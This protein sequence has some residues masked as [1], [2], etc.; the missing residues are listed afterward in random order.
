MEE[1]VETV[2]YRMTNNYMVRI[3]EDVSVRYTVLILP[4]VEDPVDLCQ[5][6][7]SRGYYAFPMH[8]EGFLYQLYVSEMPGPPKG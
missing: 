3:T 8:I 5:V 7:R 6:L 2:L 4:I 1:D